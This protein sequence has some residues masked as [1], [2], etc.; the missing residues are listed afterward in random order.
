MPRPPRRRPVWD[1]VTAPHRL[2]LG[3]RPIAP[4]ESWIEIDDDLEHDLREKDTLLRDQ[5][6]QVFVELA[7]SR[8][9]Q[10][11]ARARIAETLLAHHAEGYEMR[12]ARFHVRATGARF[13]VRADDSPALEMA[14]RWVQEDLVLMEPQRGQ[15]CLTAASVCFPTRWDLP[16]QLDRPMTEIHGR[17]PGYREQLDAA[18]TKFFD[19]MKSGRVFRR[20][21]WSLMDDPTLFQP[22][23]KM[24]T[25]PSPDLDASNAGEKIWLRVEHQ[26]LQRL[27]ESGAILF[28]IRIHRTRLDALA[29]APD[30]AGRLVAAIETMHPEMQRYKSLAMVKEAAA[31]YLA[32][33]IATAPAG[34]ID[35]LRS[36]PQSSTPK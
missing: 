23:G 26:T 20:G 22:A 32:R 36:R 25:Q 35:A 24:Q 18:S 2:S 6:P 1:T 10:R 28:T 5:R 12:G 9:A 8:P 16:S 21:N 17:V 4:D 34:R 3:L 7:R 33:A 13:D 31:E 14:S 19:G 15:W 27:P 29:A 11:E 30:V